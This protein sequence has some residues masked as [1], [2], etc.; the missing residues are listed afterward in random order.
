MVIKT[1]NSN[2]VTTRKS[3]QFSNEMHF[4]EDIVPTIQQF[5][6]VANVPESDRIDAIVQQ[7]GSRLSLDSSNLKFGFGNNYYHYT[8][9]FHSQMPNMQT[10]MR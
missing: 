10:Q 5:E 4:Y 1:L 3:R 2:N 9:N 6:Q 8:L 7:Y